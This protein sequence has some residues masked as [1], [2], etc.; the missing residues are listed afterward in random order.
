MICDLC[1]RPEES[2]PCHEDVNREIAENAKLRAKIAQTETIGARTEFFQDGEVLW[3]VRFWIR[4][5]CLQIN[6]SV[7]A[8]GWKEA[9]EKALSN[10]AESIAYKVISVGQHIED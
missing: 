1:K 7:F 6:V 3:D 8:L 5:G 9:V 10:L 2:H 4:D